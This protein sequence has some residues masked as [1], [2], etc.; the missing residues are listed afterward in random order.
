[1]AECRTR[2]V[3]PPSYERPNWQEP[4]PCVADPASVMLY[5]EP[6]TIVST[7]VSSAMAC[8][9]AYPFAGYCGF[10]CQARVLKNRIV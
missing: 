6:A 9:V 5:V 4:P 8:G 1:M 10:F 7:G 2:I 3:L